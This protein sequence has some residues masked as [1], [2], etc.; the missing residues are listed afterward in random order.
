[1]IEYLIKNLDQLLCERPSS[2]I[3]VAGDFNKL[4]L[5]NLCNCFNLKKSILYPT[6]GKNV[7]DQV[8]TNMRDMYKPTQHL[9]PLGRS[10][11]NC[12]LLVPKQKEKNTN[13]SQ[14]GKTLN[15]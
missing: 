12:L 15:T 13:N 14:K 7:L 4:N 6:R 2:A 9:P 11:Q 10:D 8:L 3:I 5:T 1:M